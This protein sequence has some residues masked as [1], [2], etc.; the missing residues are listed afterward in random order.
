MDDADVEGDEGEVADVAD[1][2]EEI[3]DGNGDGEGAI[4]EG[5]SPSVQAEQPRPIIQS[6][7]SWCL[8]LAYCDAIPALSGNP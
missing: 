4:E 7:E 1:I 5:E 3:D 6:P 2:T 8:R